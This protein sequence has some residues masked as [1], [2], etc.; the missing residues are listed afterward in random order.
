MMME[1]DS[2]QASIIPF[3]T[4]IKFNKGWAF[5]LYKF[6]ST[7]FNTNLSLANYKY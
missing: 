7:N 6:H 2:S 3:T 4:D 5:T 1:M